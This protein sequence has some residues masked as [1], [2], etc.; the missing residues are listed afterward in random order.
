MALNSTSSARAT[1]NSRRSLREVRSRVV[2]EV[3]RV[4]D[5]GGV[6]EVIADIQGLSTN[7]I[8]S[9]RMMNFKAKVKHCLDVR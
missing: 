3:L 2:E 8:R 1:V 9:I 5:A 7:T 6:S 4:G